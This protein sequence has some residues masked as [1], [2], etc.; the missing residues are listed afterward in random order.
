MTEK[1]FLY[2]G[3]PINLFN[4]SEDGALLKA[5]AE[6]FPEYQIEDP[7]QQKHAEGYARYKALKGQEYNGRIVQS[8][9]DYYFQELLPSMDGGAFVPF[10]DGKFGKGVFGEAEFLANS[11]K[12][13]YVVDFDWKNLELKGLRCF[14]PRDTFRCLTVEQTQ[15]RVYIDGDFKNGIKSFFTD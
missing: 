8:G 1:P 12:E 13:S 2:L 14:D 5:I 10:R 15:A 6:F 3:R 4:T 9:M 7:A 11:G